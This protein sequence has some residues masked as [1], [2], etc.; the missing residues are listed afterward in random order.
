MVFPNLVFAQTDFGAVDC[1]P[2]TH[3]KAQSGLKSNN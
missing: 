2:G 1:P 3:E